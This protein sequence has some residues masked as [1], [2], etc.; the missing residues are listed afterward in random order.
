[1]SLA[2]NDLADGMR[3]HERRDPLCEMITRDDALVCKLVNA[4]LRTA[5]FV[6]S[7]SA[8]D[9]HGDIVEQDWNLEHFKS[10]PVILYGH[11]SRELPIGQATKIAVELGVLVVTIKFASAEANPLAEQVWKLVQERVLRAVSVGFQPTNGSY[12]MRD[13][14]DVWVWRQPILKEVSV[15]P[16]PANHEA[17]ARMKMKGALK[18]SAPIVVTETP[19]PARA[20]N[21][22]QTRDDAKESAMDVKE[23]QAKID[24]LNTEKGAADAALKAAETKLD[25]VVKERD[26]HKAALDALTIEKAALDAQCTALTKERD[27]ALTTV[28]ELEAKTID[29]EV[30]ALVGDKIAPTEKEMFVELRKT[31]PALFTK[32]IE[33]RAPMHLA[34]RVAPLAKANGASRV[35]ELAARLR[36]A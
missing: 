7:T 33:Q 21:P 17:L 20:T 4:E 9:S 22:A 3:V 10:N 11:A 27:A 31:N 13:G 14:R 15:V 35:D 26:G 23:M 24:A 29:Q 18:S 5:E 8:V 32:M 2:T 25:A 36:D 12:E 6:A 34:A 30:E 19:A 28:A 16:V 1:M